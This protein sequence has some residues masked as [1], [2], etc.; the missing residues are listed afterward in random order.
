MKKTKDSTFVRK[1]GAAFLALIIS[2]SL[3]PIVA[4][5]APGVTEI[6][7]GTTEGEPGEDVTVIV[8]IADNPGH[9]AAVF[10]IYYDAS[11]LTLKSITPGAVLTGKSFIANTA[12]NSNFG[13]LDPSALG[14]TGNGEY[15]KIVFNIKSGASLGSSAVSIGLVGDVA[16]NYVNA[17][18]SAL[19]I[20]FNAGAVN[21]V[22]P[23][24]PPLPPPPP[25]PP[26]TYP[27]G[28]GSTGYTGGGSTAS[29]DDTTKDDSKSDD[30]T[31]TTTTQQPPSPKPT[32]NDAKDKTTGSDTIT[33]DKTPLASGDDDSP[34]FSWLLIALPLLLAALLIFFLI[35]FFWRRR[36]KEEEEEKARYR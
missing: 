22:A 26:P 5:A 36:K 4:Y 14:I 27:G 20:I 29:S 11:V 21:I 15:I 2:L 33:D 17:T 6:S 3:L 23:A 13:V 30:K 34:G 25:P 9:G 35:F 10:T 28:G 32:D 18:G 16:K 8:T 31:S 12:I 7:V 1:A 24:T 19:P